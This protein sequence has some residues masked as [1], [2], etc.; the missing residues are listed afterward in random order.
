LLAL[1]DVAIAA[2]A[3]GV[4]SLTVVDRMAQVVK[5]SYFAIFCY[6]AKLDITMMTRRRIMLILKK[7]LPIVRMYYFLEQIRVVHEFPDRI[8]CGRLA[9]RRYVQETAIR[10]LPKLPVEGVICY[11]TIFLLT[12]PKFFLKHFLVTYIESVNVH[13]FFFE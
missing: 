1:G 11:D 9:K 3:S 12:L 13:T 6:N 5:P 7:C 2:P 4:A 10:A 8:S